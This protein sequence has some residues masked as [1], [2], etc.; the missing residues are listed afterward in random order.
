MAIFWPMR[1]TLI[2]V[3]YAH[4]IGVLST[5]ASQDKPRWLRI[6]LMEIT[7]LHPSNAHWEGILTPRTTQ[8]TIR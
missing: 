6:Y 8:V 5:N 7:A 1:E 3:D 2:S 4:K